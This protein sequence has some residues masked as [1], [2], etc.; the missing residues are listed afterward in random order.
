MSAR[1]DILERMKKQMSSGVQR[2]PA[3]ILHKEKG[4]LFEDITLEDIE[5]QD[6]SPMK[7]QLKFELGI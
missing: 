2:D 3:L 7:P 4:C 1:Q 6:Y 5:I